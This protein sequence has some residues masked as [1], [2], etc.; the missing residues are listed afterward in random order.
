[1]LVTPPKCTS[2]ANID[3]GSRATATGQKDTTFVGIVTNLSFP[4]FNDRKPKIMGIAMSSSIGVDIMSEAIKDPSS[5]KGKTVGR[6][7]DHM[8]AFA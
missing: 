8:D 4:P 2:V 3:G 5:A 1:M 7:I 6:T